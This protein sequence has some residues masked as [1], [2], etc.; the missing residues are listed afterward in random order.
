MNRQTVKRLAEKLGATVRINS[1][2]PALD[3]AVEAPSGFVW[4]CAGDIHELIG[5]QWEGEFAGPVWA[6]LADRMKEGVEPCRLGACEWCKNGNPD[7]V[8]F[9]VRVNETWTRLTVNRASFL[10]WYSSTPTEEG[11]SYRRIEWRLLGGGMVEQTTEAGGSDCD[12]FVKQTTIY[13]CHV[14]DLE[15]GAEGDLKV[16]I[17]KREKAFVEEKE[18]VK[19]WEEHLYTLAMLDAE[20]EAE[21]RMGA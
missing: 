5:S 9:W 10:Y 11:Y 21:G 4:S 19:D 2:A 7:R 15:R 20:S 1:E 18:I 8:R 17:W 3:V 13:T 12:G 16:P 6:D 14:E